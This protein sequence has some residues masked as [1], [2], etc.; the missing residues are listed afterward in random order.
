MRV[1]HKVIIGPEPQIVEAE[2]LLHVAEQNGN[3]T[4]W[5]IASNTKYKFEI[6]VVPTG[7]AEVPVGQYLGTTVMTDGLVW[8]TF[9]KGA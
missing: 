8:H 1:I 9:Y 7:Y 3:L 5:Y 6:V 2:R 4:L